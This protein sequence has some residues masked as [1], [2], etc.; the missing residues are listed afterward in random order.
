MVAKRM[1]DAKTNMGYP[2]DRLPNNFDRL[3][4]PKLA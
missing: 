2:T 1:I 3:G 4:G